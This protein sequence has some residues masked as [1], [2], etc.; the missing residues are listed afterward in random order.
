MMKGLLFGTLSAFL[1][2]AIATPAV[3]AQTQAQ[4]K[5]LNPA[6]VNNLAN[7]Q[8][9]LTAFELTFLA[10]RGYLEAEGIPGYHGLIAAYHTGEITAEDIV[11]SAVNANRLDHSK[12]GDRQYISAVEAQLAA[13]SYTH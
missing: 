3:H 1:V 5:V 6:Q 10:Q 11:R 9:N 2:G 12:L 13:L 4:T 8:T 7:T